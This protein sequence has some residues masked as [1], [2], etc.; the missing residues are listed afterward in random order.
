MD[1]G[2]SRR[3]Y[4]CCWAPY[5]P[6]LPRRVAKPLQDDEVVRVTSDR[7]VELGEVGLRDRAMV[8]FLMSTGCRISEAPELDRTDWNRS[9]VIVRGKG[10]VE[11]SVVITEHARQ[12]VDRY[13]TARAAPHLRCSSATPP[14]GPAGDLASAAPKPSAT[15]SA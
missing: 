5:L 10:D 11:R 3:H 13:L 15:D 8:A 4:R 1:P 9:R 12:E 7:D 2:R 14:A 6:K